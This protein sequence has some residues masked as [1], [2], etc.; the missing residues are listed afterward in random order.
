MNETNTPAYAVAAFTTN[1]TGTI[2]AFAL[3]PL[4]GALTASAIVMR[5]P[6]HE[7]IKFAVASCAATA[8]IARVL[9]LLVMLH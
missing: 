6:L 1:A 4:L 2:V 3:L 5:Q 8:V 9:R 7:S